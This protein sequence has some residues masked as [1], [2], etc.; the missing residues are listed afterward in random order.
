ATAQA[1]A[2]ATDSTKNPYPPSTG[3]L[4]LNDPLKDN[5]R[6]NKWAEDSD[7]AGS[8]SF[9]GQAYH[10]S[11]LL[12]GIEYCFAQ[13][14]SFTNVAYQVQMTLVKGD[15]GGLLLRG[16]PPAGKFYYCFIRSDGS[17]G[18]QLYTEKSTSPAGT[19]ASGTSPAI[20]TGFG[21]SNLLAVVAQGNTLEMYVNL[22][23]VATAHD[24]TYQ[25]GYVGVAVHSNL[26][27]TEGIF[28]DAR[29]WK[30]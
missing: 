1:I 8:C 4:T 15:S 27:A 3:T 16:A 22:Q 10:A 21:Q 17:Y 23:K 13:A 11:M 6:G 24:N 12:P 26:D 28:Q 9:V 25:S 14:A 2:A 19:L 20:R 7:V 29:V 30:L 18:I 5:T